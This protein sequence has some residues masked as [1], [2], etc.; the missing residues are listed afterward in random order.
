MAGTH[1]KPDFDFAIKNWNLAN[2]EHIPEK[3]Q[4]NMEKTYHI[5][6]R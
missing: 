5:S 4:D 3:N 1:L 2:H 6:F